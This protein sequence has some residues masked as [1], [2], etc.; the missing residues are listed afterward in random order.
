MNAETV[1]QLRDLADGDSYAAFK[2]T[3]LAVG[4]TEAE[5]DLVWRHNGRPATGD[6]EVE[7]DVR[8][9]GMELHG[10]TEKAW[11]TATE[12]VDLQEWE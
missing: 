1:E 12:S 8:D 5:A 10:E 2:S 3:A 6:G 9:A 11:L 4:M 7:A